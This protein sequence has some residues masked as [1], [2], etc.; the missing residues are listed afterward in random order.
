MKRSVLS[1]WNWQPRNY[2]TISWL[3]VNK[4][5]VT[6]KV[7]TI[8]DTVLTQEVLFHSKE[9]R[10]NQRTAVHAWHVHASFYEVCILK[11]YSVRILRSKLYFATFTG[12]RTYDCYCLTPWSRVLLEKMTVTQLA[13][14][15][16]A[17]YATRKFITV[18]TRARRW[19]LSWARCIQSTPSHPISIRSIP[20][21]PCYICLDLPNNLHWLLL[22]F[23][24]YHAIQF[25]IS[26]WSSS[27]E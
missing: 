26:S 3:C 22:T 6:T 19:S 15:F 4:L 7:L 23:L 18:F 12:R 25:N 21:L 11:R 1:I 27:V 14:K 10:I 13:K 8:V 16:P 2:M 17:F 9:A 24:I 5:Q 20:I